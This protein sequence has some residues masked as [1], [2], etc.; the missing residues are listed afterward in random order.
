ML[1]AQS[2]QNQ[3][4]Q[5]P[6]KTMDSSSHSNKSSSSSSMT[7]VSAAVDSDA[8]PATSKQQKLIKV[9]LL[10]LLAAIVVY[11]ILDYTVSVCYVKG[12]CAICRCG[13]RRDIRV[14]T[15]F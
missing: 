3:P 9:G 13:C 15:Y 7:V 14:F 4:T 6:S 2:G 5:T 10:F 1:R 8:V 12:T 11:V